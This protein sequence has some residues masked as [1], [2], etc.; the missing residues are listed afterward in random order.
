VRI[1]RIL[2]VGSGSI[3]QRHL[4]LARHLLPTSII[5]VLRHR[6]GEVVPQQADGCLSTLDEAVSFHP[7]IAV[8]AGPSTTHAAMALP[9]A[10]AGTHL[11]VE[12]PLDA[13]PEAIPALLETCAQRGVVLLTGYNLRFL[14]SL[15]SFRQYVHDERAGRILSVR[16]EVGQY[17]PDWRP[18]SDYRKG[19]SASRALGG[20]V[21]LELSHEIDY[22]RWVFGEVAWAKATLSRQSRL[23]IDVED[24]AHLTLGFKTSPGGDPHQLIATVNLDFIRRDTT[25]TCLA[26]GELGTLRWNALTGVVD[27]YMAASREWQVLSALPSAGNDSYLAEWNHFLACVRGEARPLTTG[28]DGLQ[29]LRVVAAARRAAA[30]TEAA[31]AIGEDN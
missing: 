24:T 20:G 14:P 5:K 23:D 8:I 30:M 26:L 17:L 6:G 27:C 13:N 4:Q 10:N 1:E 28:A 31:C 25:R 16:C 9:L 2:I 29:T 11:L 21:L 7:D 12:K 15:Q 22:L 18:G 3:G 19:V